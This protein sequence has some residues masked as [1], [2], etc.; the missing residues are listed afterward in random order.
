[1]NSDCWCVSSTILQIIL[2]YQIFETPPS[3]LLYHL[4]EPPW[5]MLP[6]S[7]TSAIN[8]YSIT[9]CSSSTLF[10]P[11]STATIQFSTNYLLLNAVNTSW[12]LS[13]SC[14][15]HIMVVM[16]R[17]VMSCALSLLFPVNCH[18]T[19]C[20]MV[21]PRSREILYLTNYDSEQSL[22]PPTLV[23]VSL[24][25]TTANELVLAMM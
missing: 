10:E 11:I 23:F 3:S 9:S 15:G 16:T 19:R 18:V 1:M 6:R 14:C 17:G 4:D 21:T 5:H 22:S 7:T 8:S 2:S 12:Q 20:A 25:E 24:F 13:H